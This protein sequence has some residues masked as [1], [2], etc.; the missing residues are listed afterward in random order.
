MAGLVAL[1]LQLFVRT[2]GERGVQL[3]SFRRSYWLHQAGI[4]V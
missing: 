2:E 1:V 3:E 4:C